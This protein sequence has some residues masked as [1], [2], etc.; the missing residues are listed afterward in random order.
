MKS[1]QT[2]SFNVPEYEVVHEAAYRPRLSPAH[3]RHLRQIKGKTGKPI[4]KLVGEAIDAYLE[5]RKGGDPDETAYKSVA[6]QT[7]ATLRE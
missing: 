7:A 1:I 5:Q 4:S 2:A 3:L 6:S